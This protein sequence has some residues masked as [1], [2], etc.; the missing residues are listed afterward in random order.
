ML[1]SKHRLRRLIPMLALAAFVLVPWAG[2][3]QS[4]GPTA[5][6]PDP[7]AP[8]V[9]YFPATGHTLRG[10]F[11]DYWQRYG[12]LAQFGYPITE[13][14]AESDGPRDTPP[15]TVQYFERARF[16]HH[17]ENA[18]TVHEVLLGALGLAFHPADPPVPPMM[19]PSAIYF[20][21]T[22]HNLSGVFR[23]YWEAHGGLFVNGYPV[24]EA[25]D[26]VNPIDG[27]TYSV[28]YFERSRFEYHPENAGTAYDVLL[29]LL[30][31]QLAQKMGYFG[32]GSGAFPRYGKAPDFSW[33]TGQ[34]M[35]TRIQGSCTYLR[36]DAADN[37]A[38]LL[39]AGDAWTA[40]ERT[41]LAADG[42]YVILYGHL[43]GAQEPVEMCPGGR[44]YIVDRVEVNSAPTDH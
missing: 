33:V 24:S 3:A 18:G 19:N 9:Q 12:G 14:F 29:G 39:P 42:A 44:G 40:A 15:L 20:D 21:A 38:L 8:G 37:T 30:G 26:E 2:S 23:A 22:G 1:F 41:G 10:K 31:T 32:S 6:V 43:A 11:L 5:R 28:Q 16:E 7:H 27:K 17:P 36:Y 34:V 25:F 35:V 13:E 4:A